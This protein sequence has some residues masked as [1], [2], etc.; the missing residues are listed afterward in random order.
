MKKLSI[1]EKDC[2]TEEHVRR[3]LF[4]WDR[5]KH[6]GKLE[7]SGAGYREFLFGAPFFF[8]PGIGPIVVALEGAA[9]VGSLTALGAGLCSIG[10]PKKS[11]LNY[12]TEIKAGKFLLIA[13]GTN[14]EVTQAKNIIDRAGT[15]EA[16]LH[17]G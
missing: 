13:H 8:G 2:H 14:E 4:R 17:Q 6:L 1:V 10:I 11:I 7:L 15:T 5:M 3:L 16:V 9:V 12:E